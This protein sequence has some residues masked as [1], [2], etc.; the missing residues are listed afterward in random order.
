M[1]MLV[2]PLAL[3]FFLIAGGRLLMA[4]GSE[5]LFRQGQGVFTENC[6]P[7]HRANGQGLPGAFPALDNNP[8]VVGDPGP[9]IATVLNGRKGKLGRMPAWKEKLS[10]QEIAGAL[11]YIRRAW[12]NQ[13]P[14]VTPAMVTPLRGK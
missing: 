2:V 5:D 8:F 13:A 1:R 6:A 10:D 9:V 12:T 7:C 3:A 11:T 14:A 4:Q